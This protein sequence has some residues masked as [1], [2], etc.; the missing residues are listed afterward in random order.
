MESRLGECMSVRRRHERSRTRSEGPRLLAF[1][2]QVL[3]CVMN[4]QLFAK[5]QQKPCRPPD[6]SSSP[7]IFNIRLFS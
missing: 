5:V 2:E 7:C 6:N 1:G 3:A 4:K